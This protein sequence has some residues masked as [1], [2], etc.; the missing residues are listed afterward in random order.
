MNIAVYCGS[1]SGNDPKYIEAAR[2]LGRWIGE[3]GHTLVYGGAS[4]G[5]MGEIA[6]A[7]L[8][9]EGRVTGVLPRIML[10]QE[11][12]HPGLTEYIETSSM[13]ERKTRMI[14]LADAFVALPGGIGTLDEITEVMTLTSLGIIKGPIVLYDAAGYYQ[15]LKALLDNIISKGFGRKEYFSDILISDDFAKIEKHLSSKSH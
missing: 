7:V 1:S 11:R 10:I 8:K 3:N 9:A 2:T 4:K 6:D 12:K 14:D 5:L 13:A 15:P